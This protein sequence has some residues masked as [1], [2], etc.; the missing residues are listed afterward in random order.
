M[1]VNDIL[2]YLNSFAPFDTCESWDNCGLLIGDKDAG[3]DRVLVSLDVTRE[4]LN[5]AAKKGASLIIAHHPVIFGS[6]TRVLSDSVVYKAVSMGI[7]VIGFHTCF[8]NFSEGVSFILAGQLGIVNIIQNAQRPCLVAGERQYENAAALVFDI[9]KTLKANAAYVGSGKPIRKIAV[10]GGSAGDCI[11]AALNME[12]D[13]LVTGECKYHEFLQAKEMGLTLIAAGHYETEAV[14][15]P[16]LAERVKTRFPDIEVFSYN[17]KSP[18]L[19]LG[20]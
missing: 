1:K 19:T 10:C 5:E 8:D 7:S 13:A 12:A 4:T 15:V 6:L 17:E 3:A 16:V 18:I 2:E 14:C 9:N 11:G 20:L